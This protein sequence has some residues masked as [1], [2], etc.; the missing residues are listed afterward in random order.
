MT[1]RWT[2]PR[3]P[4]AAASN[5]EGLTTVIINAGVGVTTLLKGSCWVGGAQPILRVNLLVAVA[6]VAAA[7][8]VMSRRQ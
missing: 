7:L 2:R 8:R 1:R 4:E 3:R 5:T 6:T